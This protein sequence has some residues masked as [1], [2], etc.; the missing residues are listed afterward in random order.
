LPLKIPII[1]FAEIEEQ[2]Y[3]SNGSATY[4][5]HTEQKCNLEI[6]HASFQIILKNHSEKKKKALYWHKRYTETSGIE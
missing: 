5:R 3:D 1:F 4:Q 2:L 6:S